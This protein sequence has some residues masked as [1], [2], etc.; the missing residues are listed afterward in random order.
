VWI[1]DQ[2]PIVRHN[3]G[4]IGCISSLPTESNVDH[5]EFIPNPNFSAGFQSMFQSNLVHAYRVEYNLEIYRR[6]YFSNY[7]SR[8]EAIFL[9]E[10][11]EEAEKY[12]I[13]HPWHVGER[14][15]MK[16]RSHGDY[17][18][19]RHDVGWIDFMLGIGSVDEGT[20]DAVTTEYWKGNSVKGK[21]FQQMGKPAMYVSNFEV[22][23]RGRI[24]LDKSQLK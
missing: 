12:K 17:L 8:L 18:F 5:F 6:A 3:V 16:G 15:L 13:H 19:S 4:L 11:S 1:D 21:K 23:Y 7:P 2:N 24:D 22:L 14:K 20:V 10:T 9:F